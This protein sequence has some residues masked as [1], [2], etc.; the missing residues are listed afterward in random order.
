MLLG[1]LGSLM[2]S[3]GSIMRIL[4]R[5]RRAVLSSELVL[6]VAK[7][8]F[9]LA[10]QSGVANHI[11]SQDFMYRNWCPNVRCGIHAMLHTCACL[12][13]RKKQGIVFEHL[14]MLNRIPG[15]RRCTTCLHRQTD[16]PTDKHIEIDTHT[17]KQSKNIYI[18]NI[19]ICVYMYICISI[20]FKSVETSTCKR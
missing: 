10:L 11:H 12:M 3:H 17:N 14:Q 9:V 8:H 6:D 16:R 19:Y 13:Q 5:P 4:G 2:G 7:L 15:R 20:P 1:T 18:Y